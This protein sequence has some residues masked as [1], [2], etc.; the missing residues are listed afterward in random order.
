MKKPRTI[1]A[2]FASSIILLL[3]LAG[4]FVMKPV[5]RNEFAGTIRNVLDEK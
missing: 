2:S 5:D 4:L 1:A 3:S